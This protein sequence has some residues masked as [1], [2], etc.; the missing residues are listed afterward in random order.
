MAGS[1]SGSIQ[2]FNTLFEH[3]K[4]ENPQEDVVLIVDEL[5]KDLLIEI[6]DTMNKMG[7]VSYYNFE[8]GNQRKRYL[9]GKLQGLFEA[10]KIISANRNPDKAKK[11]L[12]VS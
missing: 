3:M 1:Y 12:E 8:K 2:D 9:E 4:E 5:F 7:S 11:L 6:E 10:A